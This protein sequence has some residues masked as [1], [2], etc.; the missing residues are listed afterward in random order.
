M[1]L[2]GNLTRLDIPRPLIRQSWTT[3]QTPSKVKPFSRERRSS[4]RSR[5]RTH[6]GER[7]ADYKRNASDAWTTGGLC[8]KRERE[9]ES[10]RG[11]ERERERDGEREREREGER[12]GERGGEGERERGRER[13]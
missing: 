12:D 7:S 6:S 11:R 13:E 8:L 2:G 9:R 10:E 4:A 5:I 1:K 3:A